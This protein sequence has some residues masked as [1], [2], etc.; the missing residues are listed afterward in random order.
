MA[1]A[2]TARV[3]C[4]R[5]EIE[6]EPEPPEEPT[7]PP[8]D[9]YLRCWKGWLEIDADQRQAY[10]RKGYK[11]GPRRDGRQTVW[12]AKEDKTT[13][14]PVLSLPGA[15]NRQA[16]VLQMRTWLYGPMAEVPQG[17]GC[18]PQGL[19]GRAAPLPQAARGLPQGL[20]RHTA[21]LPEGAAEGLSKGYVGK[22]PNCRKIPTSCPDGYVGKPPH[23]HKLPK[24]CPQGYVGKPPQTATSC[25]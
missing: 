19:R 20:R 2:G 23:C 21:Q 16:A 9:F 6:P 24:H 5:G 18:V 13:T 25:R 10:I 1:R 3:R 22:P 15:R 12:C 11:V 4:K 17:A 8:T 7:L 14:P